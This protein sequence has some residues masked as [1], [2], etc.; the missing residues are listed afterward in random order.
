MHRLEGDRVSHVGTPMSSS[1]VWKMTL[2]VG[3]LVALNGGLLIGAAFFATSTMLQNQIHERL[4]TLAED[5]Q[6]I[7]ATTLRQLEE[8]TVGFAKRPR[9]H[10]LLGDHNR[11]QSRPEQFRN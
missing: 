10:Q 5:R 9:I 8:R 1:I 7:L 4:S 2:F 6:E 3:V 11:G